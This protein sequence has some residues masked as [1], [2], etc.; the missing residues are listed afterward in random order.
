MLAMVLKDGALTAALRPAPRPGPR[1]PLIR[2]KACGVCRTDLRLLDGDLPVEGEIIPGHEIV[3]IVEAVGDEAKGFTLGD[4]VGVTWLGR[5]CG[6]CPYCRENAEN[7]C[8]RPLFTGWTRDGGYAQLTVADAAS[9][10]A[11]PE[12]Y[13]DVEAAPLL[14]AGLI[15]F[16]AWRMAMQARPVQ[17]LG[18]FGF[19]AAAHLLA[20]L[21]ISEGQYVYAFTRD[22]DLAA[23]DLARGLGCVWTGGSSQA[24]PEQLDAAIIFAAVGSLV[25]V[26]LRAVRKGGTVV[27][28]GIHMSDLPAMAYADLWGERR[29][30]SVANLAHADAQDYL[31]RAAA[32]G[33]RAHVKTYPLR[34]AGQALS[35]LRAGVFSGAA[36][37]TFEEGTGA[38]TA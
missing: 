7:L 24:A 3:G 2:V 5:T 16:R 14:C 20:Q 1:E 13:G 8:D 15:G 22:G 19:G 28:G 32:A 36:V 6:R 10:V 17:R 12:A 29:L 23:Q 25:P 27:C 21:A 33:V 31:P 9:C 18:L 35:D 4:R 34:K 11:I 37:L 26:A 30:V 38:A